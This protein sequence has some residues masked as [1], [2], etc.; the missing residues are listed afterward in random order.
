MS[1]PKIGDRAKFVGYDDVFRE[2]QRQ[3]KMGTIVLDA[4][5]NKG[6]NFGGGTC[7]WKVDDQPGVYITA[8]ADLEI[9][10]R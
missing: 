3:G 4:A 9:V 1:N 8:L 10:Q 7:G 5:L 2:G 6:E